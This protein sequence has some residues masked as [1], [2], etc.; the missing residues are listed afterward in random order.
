MKNKNQ[1]KNSLFN[2]NTTAVKNVLKSKEVRK[3]AKEVLKSAK[4]L[5]D[6]F[7]VNK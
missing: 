3:A 2:I 4:N 5:T 6:T 1:E 7:D